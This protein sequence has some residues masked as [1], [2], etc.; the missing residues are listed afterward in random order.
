MQDDTPFP[1][2][3]QTSLMARM[4][5]TNPRGW[6]VGT[7]LSPLFHRLRQTIQASQTQEITKTESARPPPRAPPSAD[8][9]AVIRPLPTR[10]PPATTG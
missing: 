2:P 7:F 8:P 6:G 9:V 1:D 4:K 5:A 10:E 3:T